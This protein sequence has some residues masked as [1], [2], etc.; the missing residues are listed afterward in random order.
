MS[1][2]ILTIA[3][4]FNSEH[5]ELFYKFEQDNSL[6]IQVASTLQS[7]KDSTTE[8]EYKSNLK[9]SNEITL[10]LFEKSGEQIVDSCNIQGAKD[11]KTCSISFAPLKNKIKR[12]ILLAATDYAMTVLGMEEVFITIDP[13]DKNIINNLDKYNFENLGEEN[14]C[15][16]YLKEKEEQNVPTQIA[17]FC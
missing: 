16:M 4:P 14:G 7:I 2:N 8:Q 5:I 11:I 13:T 15:V 17:Q 1:T 3:N 10:V 12:P 9:N 6:P